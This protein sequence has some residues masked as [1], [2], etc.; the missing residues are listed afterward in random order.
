[1]VAVAVAVMKKGEVCAK[2]A[3]AQQRL[4]HNSVFFTGFGRTW[5]G[6]LTSTKHI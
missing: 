3:K 2:I 1:M 4:R 6:E 5:R